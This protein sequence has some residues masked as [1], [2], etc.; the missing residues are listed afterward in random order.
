[1]QKAMSNQKNFS[2][3]Q[4]TIP[5]IEDP[6]G[7]LMP[8]GY[9]PP[10]HAFYRRALNEPFS[11]DVAMEREGPL[12]EQMRRLLTEFVAAD[13]G[14]FHAAVS[15]P[16]STQAFLDF[17]GVPADDLP[18]LLE[19][20]ERVITGRTASTEELARVNAE[21]WPAL[22]AYWSKALQ[23]RAAEPDPPAD[24]LTAVSHA[25]YRD[26]P[27]TL[28]EQTRAMT[29]ITPAA[30]D[31]V[32]TTLSKSAYHL[33]THADDLRR[34][35]A[36]RELVP[37]AVEEL[38]R[39]YPTSS[40]ARVCKRDTEVRGVEIHEGEPVWLATETAN[41][42]PDVFDSPDVVDF[43]REPN[44]H[45]TFGAGPHR[46]L[47]LHVARVWLRIALEEIVTAMPEFSLEGDDY[48]PGF[49]YGNVAGVD[50]LRLVVG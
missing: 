35:V 22:G 4:I 6:A 5:K 37:S 47:G 15:I 18:Q 13:G 45:L 17:A 26:R 46:C 33:A 38:L 7:P 31:T 48:E 27:L 25:K 19:W 10:E 43:T 30:L 49:H 20:T 28:D 44:P 50:H 14:D 8:I 2:T 12:R 34:L 29:F 9:G 3:E 42:D 23:E 41:R 32:G 40:G 36:D 21:V 11:A 1:M 16:Y 24:L 39:F